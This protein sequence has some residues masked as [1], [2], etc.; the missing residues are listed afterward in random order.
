M[1][2]PTKEEL[3]TQWQKADKKIKLIQEALRAAK[4]EKK[5]I[6]LQFAAMGEDAPF[7]IP[8]LDQV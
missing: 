4:A 8:G 3:V 5:Q 2:T 1:E 7:E 6:K